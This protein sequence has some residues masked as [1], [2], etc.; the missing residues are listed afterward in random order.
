MGMVARPT[1]VI[2]L[3]IAAGIGIY[4]CYLLTLPFLPALTWALV[5]AVVLE[6][7]H[8]RL[9]ARVKNRNLAASLSVAIAVI[10]VGLPLA[11]IAQQ[12][13]RDAISGVS[14]VQQVIGG[15]N[16]S[17]LLRDYPRL[18]SIATW[19]SEQFDPAGTI[20]AIGQWLTRHSTWF[21]VGSVNQVITL[22]L[23][24][25]LLF[26]FLRD[27]REALQAIQR[28]LPLEPRE[29]AQLTSRFA[30]T[31]HATLFGTVLVAAVQGALGGLMFWWLDLPTPAFW[32]LV[33]G[34]LAIVPVLGAFVVWVPAAVILLLQ[35]RLIGALVLSVWGALVI[36]TI[37]NLLY[38][39]LVGNRLQMH[40]LVAF[41]GA[42]GGI[43]LFG[44]SGLV[45][46]PAIIAITLT[47]LA[48]LN[49]R[50]DVRTAAEVAFTQDDRYEDG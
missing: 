21:V 9:E 39:V 34:V 45:L 20:A 17:D 26:Y 44:A 14:Y 10:V 35:D 8:R 18:A 33:M 7:A 38:P 5:L 28:L 25:Y 19:I 11:L 50:L 4:V 1:R 29:T 41:I 32:G 15:W 6:P 16:F 31:V 2:A 24:F 36:G 40:T 27:R 22:M 49:R 3:P 37:D 43:I 47:L 13:V 23:V 30:E 42:V 48:I 12:L 46:G